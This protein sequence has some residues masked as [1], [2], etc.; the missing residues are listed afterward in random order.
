MSTER[1]LSSRHLL[2]TCQILVNNFQFPK[3]FC[4]RNTGQVLEFDCTDNG[5]WIVLHQFSNHHSIL[6]CKNKRVLKKYKSY[7]FYSRKISSKY[8][9]VFL[10]MY[11]FVGSHFYHYPNL[12][13]Q[14]LL[15]MFTPLQTIIITIPTWP[16][17]ILPTIYFNFFL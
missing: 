16:I 9:L 7:G 14:P 2:K 6:I 5:D 17:I 12:T 8:L 15:P 3:V 10:H 4:S 1:I 11:I 13:K